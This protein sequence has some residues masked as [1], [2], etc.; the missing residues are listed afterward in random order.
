MKLATLDS[1]DEIRELRGEARRDGESL[2]SGIAHS[3]LSDAELEEGRMG[4]LQVK[5]PLVDGDQDAN[6]LSVALPRPKVDAVHQREEFGVGQFLEGRFV[7]A[8]GRRNT[9]AFG[10]RE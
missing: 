9:H 1:A 8:G 5:T 6:Q 7:H 2:R 4:L 3:E 10:G